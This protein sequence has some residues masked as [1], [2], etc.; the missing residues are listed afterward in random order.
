MRCSMCGSKTKVIDTRHSSNN[1]IYRKRRCIECGYEFISMEF[2]IFLTERTI[3][4]WN[5]CERKRIKRIQQ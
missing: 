3:E 4:N 1:E 2:E 5:K